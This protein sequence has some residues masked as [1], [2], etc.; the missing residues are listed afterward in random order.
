M[1]AREV[2][3]LIQRNIS[4]AEQKRPFVRNKCASRLIDWERKVAT[5]FL[6]PVCAYPEPLYWLVIWHNFASMG[7]TLSEPTGDRSPYRREQGTVP[8]CQLVG[9]PGGGWDIDESP[10][11]CPVRLPAG[12]KFRHKARAQPAL[13]AGQCVE[14]ESISRGVGGSGQP[15]LIPETVEKRSGCAPAPHVWVRD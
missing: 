10:F 9:K 14:S 12:L 3:R 6:F 7:K 11:A 4:S 13:R 8:G 5:C 2:K 1:L 15:A